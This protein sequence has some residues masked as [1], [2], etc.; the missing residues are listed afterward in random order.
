[1]F[2]ASRFLKNVFT[3]E[4]RLWLI[5][6]GLATVYSCTPPACSLTFL[7]HIPVTG[8]RVQVS[9]PGSSLVR[10]DLSADTWELLWELRTSIHTM[11]Y[12]NLS[13]PNSTLTNSSQ[14]GR[15]LSI[16]VELLSNTDS[17]LQNPNSDSEVD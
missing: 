1:M 8:D 14:D 11:I 13:D 16:L 10:C 2:S 4:T 5:T 3:F 9:F 15:L 12:R 6:V 17:T 7:S